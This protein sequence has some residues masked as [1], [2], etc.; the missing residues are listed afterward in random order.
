MKKAMKLRN[1]M[2]LWYTGLTVVSIGAFACVLYF[3]TSYVLQ[4]MLEREARLSLQQ[5]SAQV[6]LDGGMLTFENEVPISSGSMYYIM[7]D[8]GSELATYGKDITFFENV[9]IEPGQFRTVR[10]GSDEWLLLDSELLSVEPGIPNH[11]K[12][13]ADELPSPESYTVQREHYTV[14]VRVAV[15]CA[16]KQRVLS[17]LL[18]VFGI[19][20][21]LITLFALIG[22]FMIAKRA[23]RPI[24]Q[25]IHSADIIS[26]GDLSERIPDAPAHDE[27]GELTD[28]LNR[29]LS[30][31]ETSFIREKRFASDAS[32]ELRTPVTVMRACTEIMLSDKSATDDQKSSLQTMLIE[33]DRMQKI[34]KQLLT[35]TRG[36]EGQYPFF[37]ES[38]NLKVISDTV[39]E[40]FA[41]ILSEKLITLNVEVADEIELKA[42]QSLLTELM[43]NLVENAIKYGKPHGQICVT[44]SLQNESVEIRISDDGIGIAKEA[45]P[46]IFDRFYRVD[47]ARDRS[48]T[49]LGLSIVKWIV[50]AH[51]GSIRTESE[52]GQGTTF[53]IIL[54]AVQSDDR[55]V[56]TPKI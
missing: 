9:P 10:S 5:L 29:M 56:N 21:P 8:N 40:T 39:A 52:L 38:V 26:D 3:M 33:C 20:I 37:M 45:L 1:K 28:T 32:H 22:G 53:I 44:A 15:S 27:L 54:P 31:V 36:Q 4:E 6:E 7:E 13:D 48:G 43:L 25:I 19:G 42:D 23:L 51:H 18:M 41:D 12:G 35:I 2:T 47:T 30:S 24:R 50:Q 49:G 17:M 46:F 11:G 16:L 55:E 34:I 14:R